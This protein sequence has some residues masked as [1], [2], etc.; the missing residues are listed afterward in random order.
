MARHLPGRRHHCE[1]C[2]RSPRTTVAARPVGAV[3][4]HGRPVTLK[5]ARGVGRFSSQTRSGTTPNLREH[6]TVIRR[7][8]GSAHPPTS[9]LPA[10]RGGER[11][12]VADYCLA[13]AVSA[14][15]VAGDCSG[16]GLNRA[17][18]CRAASWSAVSDRWDGCDRADWHRPRRC[19]RG[20]GGVRR[21][22]GP[23]RLRLSAVLVGSSG[24]HDSEPGRIDAAIAHVPNRAGLDI[25][26]R[27]PLHRR[28]QCQSS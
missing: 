10:M 18:D 14:V 26:H 5:T 2:W 28:Q 11:R 1:N 4:E 17:A 12:A 3:P 7:R 8:T 21:E 22:L 20:C 9:S 25:D 19:R 13:P 23:R 16:L 6:P 27:P 15:V 24:R